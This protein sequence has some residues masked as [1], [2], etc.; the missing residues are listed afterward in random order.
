[1]TDYYEIL[2]VPK[3][4]SPDDIKKAFRKAAMKYHPDK[5]G[6]KEK[7][8]KIQEAY[9]VLKDPE[10]RAGYDNPRPPMQ[11]FDFSQFFGGTFANVHQ[12]HVSPQ[13]CSDHSYNCKISLKDVYTGITKRFK[14][15]RTKFCTSCHG[16]CGH[17][18]GAG[19]I[20]HR[21]S[22]GPFIQMSQQVCMKCSGSGRVLNQ[23][24]NS[25]QLC[26][27]GNITEERL[28][29]LAIPPATE[30][31]KQYVINGW[32]EQASK[33]NQEPGN[34]IVT[35]TI[36]PDPHFT[37]RG[38]DLV[39]TATI[40]LKESIIGSIINVPHF[41]GSLPI[42]TNGFGIINPQKQY[43]VY[44]KGLIDNSGKSGNLHIHFVI[45]YPQVNLNHEQIS[46]LSDA[47]TKC[48]LP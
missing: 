47:F 48:N 32:G 34:L 29:E 38:L 23:P 4:A 2:G 33:S 46:T 6:D 43:T 27:S 19:T 21:I 15:K 36:D 45:T 10:T 14:V 25:C 31:G 35:I 24:A 42:D 11:H 16:T 12:Q 41:A 40:S 37:R 9:D 5:G 20:S 39:Y 17:C 22:H 44:E 28:V 7:F 8:Q 1:M 18:K 13:R 3:D 26:S 30:N